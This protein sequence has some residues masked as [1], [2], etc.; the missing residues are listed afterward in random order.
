MRNRPQS[1]GIKTCYL[2]DGY[3]LGGMLV[4]VKL[5]VTHL[6]LR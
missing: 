2:I 5:T 3:Q 6:F 1:L 4:L